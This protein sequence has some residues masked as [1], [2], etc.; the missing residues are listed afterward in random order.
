[1]L[2]ASDEGVVVAHVGD[3]AVVARGQDGNWRALSWPENGEYASTTYFVTDDPAPRLRIARLAPEFDAYAAF[4]D[5]IEDLALDHTAAMPHQPF[6]RSM[7]APL[8]G[9]EA[10]GKDPSLSSALAK[11]LDSD[12]VCARTD[13]D[14]SLILASCR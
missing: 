4:S 5:G 8:D 2:V 12:R 10:F 9:N 3:G 1:M 11:F 14:K 13:D 6:F 7:I